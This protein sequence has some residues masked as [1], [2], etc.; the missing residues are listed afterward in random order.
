MPKIQI[1]RGTTQEI[2]S[3]VPDGGE[4]F[5]VTDTKKFGIGDGSTTVQNIN[6]YDGGWVQSNAT[7]TENTSWTGSAL[8]PFSLSNY[9][10]ND[11]YNYEVFVVGQAVSSATSGKFCRIGLTSDICGYSPICACISRSNATQYANGCA[12]IPVGTG[13]YLQQYST[14]ATTA[15][16]T[17]SVYVT[18][19]RRIGTNS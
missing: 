12:V 9:L 3:V 13:R 7:L 4:P 2:N 15:G 16:G 1:R 17:I 8:Q 6:M 11:N 5:Y 18:G 14:T 19:Y 10:P